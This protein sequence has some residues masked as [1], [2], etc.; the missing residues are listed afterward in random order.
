MDL[1]QPT[2]WSAFEAQMDLVLVEMKSAIINHSTLYSSTKAEVLANYQ[3]LNVDSQEF[4][5]TANILYAIH[6]NSFIDFAPIIVEYS[7]VVEKQLRVLLVG[8]LPTNAKM[9]GQIV[10]EIDNQPIYPY[11]S[12]LTDSRAINQLRKGSTH[13]GRLTKTD[14]DDIRTILFTNGLLSR[15]V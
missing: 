3:H 15:L 14:A 9:L 4:L 13:T 1:D 7:K 6:Q 5:T 10:G 12:Y 2:G 8:Q 11:N